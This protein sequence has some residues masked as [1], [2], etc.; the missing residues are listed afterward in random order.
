LDVEVLIFHD[1][2]KKT[3][4]VFKTFRVCAFIRFFSC[5]FA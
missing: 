1:V 3:L 2:Y 5:R 4:K